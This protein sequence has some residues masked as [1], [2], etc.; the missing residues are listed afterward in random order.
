MMKLK[1]HDGVTPRGK[2]TTQLFGSCSDAAG[3]HNAST[4]L[5]ARGDADTQEEA[6][7]MCLADARELH[8]ALAV[9]L[10]EQDTKAQ[11]PP[12]FYLR[13]TRETPQGRALW[14]RPERCGYTTIVE[15]AGIYS[16][17]E[18]MRLVNGN[19]GDTEA[20]PVA[21]VAK[22]SQ[23]VVLAETLADNARASKKLLR[24][25]KYKRQR[26]SKRPE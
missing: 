3:T 20:V 19:S 23:T 25:R 13:H 21:L 18:A 22:S 24:I 5:R 1:A 14:W 6:R 12:M 4:R 2:Y 7:A 9:W 15:M 11:K 16:E 26:A 8:A 10:A 17:E